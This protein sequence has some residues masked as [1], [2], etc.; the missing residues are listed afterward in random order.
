MTNEKP[1][2]CGSGPNKLNFS[3][4]LE[5]GLRQ[6]RNGLTLGCLVIHGIS[7]G[8]SFFSDSGL[9][10][11]IFI[12]SRTEDWPRPITWSSFSDFRL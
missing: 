3:H 10:L 6:Q 5:A 8:L 9:I 11:G 1:S 7:S 4:N 12:A 2:S